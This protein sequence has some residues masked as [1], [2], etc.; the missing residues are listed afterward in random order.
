MLVPVLLAG[1]EG[2]R[3]WPLSTG[4]IPKQ[5]LT[6][7][8]DGK[9]FYQQTFDRACIKGLV[10]TILTVTTDSHLNRIASVQHIAHTILCEPEPRNTAA[11]VA[12]ASWFAREY[13][14]NPLLW[15]MPCDHSIRDTATLHATLHQAIPEA[16]AGKIITFGITPERPETHYGYIITEQ[17]GNTCLPVKKFLE[18]PPLETLLPLYQAQQCYWNSG[19]FLATASTLLDALE[20]YA[21]SLYETVGLCVKAACAEDNPL[22]FN[23]TYYSS[24]PSLPIDK[25][26]MEHAENLVVFPVDIGWSDVGSWQSLWNYTKHAGNDNTSEACTNCL[27]YLNKRYPLYGA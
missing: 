18:K 9:T 15:I 12:L 23:K 7:A 16:E 26:V 6:L 27:D 3:L 25:A 24:L 22:F 13:W 19:M 17:A 14:G 20:R 4:R 10:D 11:A 1:G 8:Q 5:F 21:P 2:K